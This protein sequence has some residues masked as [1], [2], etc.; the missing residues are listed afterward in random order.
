MARQDLDW[1]PPRPNTTASLP[2]EDPLNIL[3]DDVEKEL[4][5]LVGQRPVEE[6]RIVN[7]VYA[8]IPAMQ[9]FLRVLGSLGCNANNDLYGV[10]TR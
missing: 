4:L 3:L 7:A 10:A 9:E 6:R 1:W 5:T 2:Y 8:P